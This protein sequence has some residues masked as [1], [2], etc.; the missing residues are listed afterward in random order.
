I[1]QDALRTNMRGAGAFFILEGSSLSSLVPESVSQVLE[2]V[3]S[4]KL[5]AF[6]N[7][8]RNESAISVSQTVT[9]SRLPADNQALE[10]NLHPWSLIA[11]Q[12][13]HGHPT[14]QPGGTVMITYYTHVPE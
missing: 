3:S 4:D 12:H 13:L 1:W 7:V 5:M 14:K 2:N 9:I 6:F 10:Q 8:L 11:K